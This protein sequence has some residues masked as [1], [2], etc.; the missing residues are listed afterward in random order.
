MNNTNKEL[1]VEQ[2][3]LD[4]FMNQLRD[5]YSTQENIKNK[6][7]KVNARMKMIF[8]G[9]NGAKEVETP[10][11]DREMP[12]NLEHALNLIEGQ[13]KDMFVILEDT[14]SLV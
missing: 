4:C 2:N 6:M 8:V 10:E 14:S 13:Q 11:E 7:E 12:D 5:I 3:K 1:R 9:D